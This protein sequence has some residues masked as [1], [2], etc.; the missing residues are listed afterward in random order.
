MR[1]RLRREL[2]MRRRMRVALVTGALLSS[3]GADALTSTAFAAHLA[4]A[5]PAAEPYLGLPSSS[6]VTTP[7]HWITVPAFPNLTFDDP[8]AMT[9]DPRG[10]RLYVVE[11]E[12]RVVSFLNDRNATESTVVL[13]LRHQTQGNSDS[14]MLSIAFHPQFGVPGSPNRGYLTRVA[15]YIRSL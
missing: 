15:S 12:G 13:D 14:G 3:F 7:D 6:P 2:P 10:E 1:P 9:P 5:R 11:R 8:I 4:S